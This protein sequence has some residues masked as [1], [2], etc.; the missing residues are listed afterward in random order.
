MGL[1]GTGGTR[2]TTDL[3]TAHAS[4]AHHSAGASAFEN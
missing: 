2:P 4:G 1:D 3:R